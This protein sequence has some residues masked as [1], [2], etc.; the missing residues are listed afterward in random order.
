MPWTLQQEV[1]ATRVHTA[2]AGMKEILVGRAKPPTPDRQTI[3]R[4]DRGN[5]I[6]GGAA[7]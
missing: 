7:G 4:A 2:Q 6:A 5:P 1:L 3:A